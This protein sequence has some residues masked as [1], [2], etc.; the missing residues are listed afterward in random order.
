MTSLVLITVIGLVGD[1][2]N[3]LYTIDYRIVAISQVPLD[4]RG[5]GL[6]IGRRVPKDQLRFIPHFTA[7][8]NMLNDY[9]L[10]DHLYFI[11]RES[12]DLLDACGNIVYDDRIKEYVFTDVNHAKTAFI[13]MNKCND[14]GQSFCN[15][16]NVNGYDTISSFSKYEFRISKLSVNIVREVLNVGV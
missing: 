14:D 16:S 13:A 2:M 12:S 8:S 7:W 4:S 9:K 15:F 1:L 10:R 6:E 11:K 3:N 5:D